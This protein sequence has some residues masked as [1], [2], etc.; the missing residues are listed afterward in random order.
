MR[1]SL[2]VEGVA[3]GI[4][5]GTRLHPGREQMA[6][7]IHQALAQ[8]RELRARVVENRWFLGY[9]PGARLAGAFAA[10]AGTFILGSDLVPKTTAAHVI[11]WGLICAF[12]VITNYGALTRWFLEQPSEAREWARLRP[13]L[14]ALPALFAGGV[15]TLALLA[16][17]AHDLLFGVW[18]L[19][20][21]LMHTS[22]R[23]AL[24]KEIFYLGC[25]YLA[26]GTWYLMVYDHR[27]FTDPYPMGA[28]FF[29]GECIGAAILLRHRERSSNGE[30]S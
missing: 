26:A 1:S 6:F 19:L 15:L 11:G 20:F 3:D 4:A 22:S 30:R 10:C 14:D 24:P 25:A 21:G 9:S 27:D 8:V 28:V 13:V 5:D 23:H 7:D 17:G 18:M 29:A 12:S 16:S 2:M